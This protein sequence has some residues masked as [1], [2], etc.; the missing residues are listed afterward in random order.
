MPSASSGRYQSRLF[1]FFHQH[2]Q[3]LSSSVGQTWRKVKVATNWSLEALLYPVFVL[4]QKAVDSAG[5]QLNPQVETNQN[6][7]N[8][9]EDDSNSSSENLLIA[10]APIINL[11]EMVKNLPSRE[12][13]SSLAATETR[14]NYVDYHQT[15][16]VNETVKNYLPQIQGVATHLKNRH[17][18]LVTNDNK[19]LDILT[20]KQQQRLQDKIISEIAEYCHTWRL[21][22][23]KKADNQINVLPEINQLLNKLTATPGKQQLLNSSEEAEV[24]P[25]LT[26]LDSAIAQLES[27][28][29]LPIS[30][31]FAGIGQRL[32]QQLDKF[33][34]GKSQKITLSNKTDSQAIVPVSG[35]SLRQQIN[36]LLYS[37]KNPLSYQTNSKPQLVVV[38]QKLRQQLSKFIHHPEITTSNPTDLESQT[39]KVLDLIRQAVDYFFGSESTPKIGDNQNL[40][41]KTRKKLFPNFVKAA[42]PQSEYLETETEDLWLTFGDLFGEEVEIESAETQETKQPRLTFKKPNSKLLKEYQSGGN[43]VKGSNRKNSDIVSQNH[44]KAKSRRITLPKPEKAEIYTFSNQ[45]VGDKPDYIEINASTISYEKHPIELILDW[46]DRIILWIEERIANN[47]RRASLAFQFIQRLFGF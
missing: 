10:D 22:K 14:I 32:K 39:P 27:S 23:A 9:H 6:Q 30:Q 13:D 5:Q 8:S 42:L 15:T 18:V 47:L 17:L 11:L 35:K 4:I 2:S 37:E 19:I 45:E 16:E 36:Q 7:L 31:T 1:N 41:P 12:S 44:Q 28:T 26:K 34:F 29:F 46:L 24:K 20:L 3:R 43:L 21:L 38:G 25:Y 33:V 40:N